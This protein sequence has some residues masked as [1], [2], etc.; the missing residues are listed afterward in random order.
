MEKVESR[1]VEIVVKKL[2]VCYEIMPRED[3]IGGLC[4]NSIIICVNNCL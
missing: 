2:Y 4:A 3:M 1:L